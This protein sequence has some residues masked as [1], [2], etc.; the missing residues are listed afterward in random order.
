MS[1]VIE[2]V[3]L[4]DAAKEGPW[5]KEHTYRVFT[6]PKYAHLDPPKLVRCGKNTTAVIRSEWEDFKRRMIEQDYKPKDV[7]AKFRST[8]KASKNSATEVYAK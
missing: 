7:A 4:A 5:S 2:F 6:D 8:H 3:R 1:D